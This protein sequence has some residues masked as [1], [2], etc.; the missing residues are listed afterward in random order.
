[1]SQ[2]AFLTPPPRTALPES[3]ANIPDPRIARAEERLAMLREMAEIGMALLRDLPR[4]ALETQEPP[5]AE[6][7]ADTPPNRPRNPRPAPAKTQ[8]SPSPASRAPFA[9]PSP[10]K[11]L[12]R[13]G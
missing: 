11:R 5:E 3:F 10:S 6:P 4:R 8:P 13:T 12:S 2:D 1:M 7:D 9:S